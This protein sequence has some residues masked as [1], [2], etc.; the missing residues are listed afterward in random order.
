MLP[1]YT[2]LGLNRNTRG[3]PARKYVPRPN[4][5]I[6]VYVLGPSR[7]QHDYLDQYGLDRLP[8]HSR[9][10]I[11]PSHP[12]KYVLSMTPNRHRHIP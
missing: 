2:H 5:S 11:N 9:P 12:T 7:T 8:T 3:N 1:Q 6:R 4:A 10:N